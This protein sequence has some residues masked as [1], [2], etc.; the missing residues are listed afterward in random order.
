LIEAAPVMEVARSEDLA[1]LPALVDRV[2][3]LVEV[4][5]G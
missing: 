3:A 2:R 1:D 5:R 4:P